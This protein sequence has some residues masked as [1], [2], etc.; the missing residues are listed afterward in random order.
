[1]LAS[2]AEALR[3][4]SA[5]RDRLDERQSRAHLGHRTAVEA[6]RSDRCWYSAAERERFYVDTRRAQQEAAAGARTA[7]ERRRAERRA[8]LDALERLNNESTHRGDASPTAEK[9]EGIV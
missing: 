8:V 1:V 7:R 2:E 9:S 5:A 4:L 6:D 3:R